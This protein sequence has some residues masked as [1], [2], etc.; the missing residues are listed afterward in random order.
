MKPAHMLGASVFAGA[1]LASM[2]VSS[3]PAS[4][5]T[6]PF[7]PFNPDG[8]LKSPAQMMH[9]CNN[10][11]YL[12]D[13]SDPACT[14]TAG[15]VTKTSVI[16]PAQMISSKD[17]TGSPVGEAC[18][19]SGISVA[20]DF[21]VTLSTGWNFGGFLFPEMEW[22]HALMGSTIAAAIAPEASYETV[23]ERT[24]GSTE[25]VNADYHHVGW[26][27]DDATYDESQMTVT[28]NY[29]NGKTYAEDPY[30]F[31]TYGAAPLASPTTDSFQG[32]DRIMST[33]EIKNCT[34]SDWQTYVKTLPVLQQAST[35]AWYPS[36]GRLVNSDITNM[37][38]QALGN[39][40]TV[41]QVD[42]EPCT[43]SSSSTQVWNWTWASKG[44]QVKNSASGLCLTATGRGNNAPVVQQTC[45]PTLLNQQWQFNEYKS[46]VYPLDYEESVYVLGNIGY[47]TY[48]YPTSRYS[49][50]DLV[51][52][53]QNFA[54]QQEYSY[55]S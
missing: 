48:L 33:D 2:L 41:A 38:I 35:L 46:T 11:A 13:R 14:V 49:K 36:N 4:A 47:G 3:T 5:D 15:P 9:D 34:G 7:S 26:L 20:K 19:T 21:E 28:A 18:S 23:T 55:T 22:E 53:A 17:G 30:K 51:T 50:A 16:F 25:T 42:I 24:H 6:A 8:S 12:L 10:A 44:W 52:G 39:S 1:L 45:Q 32:L 29:F 54:P 40:K 43:T 37:C 31:T 27:E